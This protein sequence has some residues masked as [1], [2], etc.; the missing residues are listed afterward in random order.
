[1][2]RRRSVV[3]RA[4]RVYAGNRR[5]GFFQTALAPMLELEGVTLERWKGI[6][7]LERRSIP[8]CVVEWGTKTLL[9]PSGVLITRLGDPG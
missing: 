8:A 3:L 4:A 5:I 9:T 1:L 7:L 6:Q 2:G